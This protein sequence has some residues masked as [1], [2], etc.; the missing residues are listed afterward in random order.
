LAI[1]NN[2][3]HDNTNWIYSKTAAAAQYYQSPSGQHVW[4]IAPSGTA[5]NAITFT[6]A[7]TLTAD[8]NLGINIATPNFTS[9]N[10]KTI[11][12]NGTTSAAVSLSAGGANYAYLYADSGAA[13]FGATGNYPLSLQTNLTTKLQITGGGNVLIGSPTDSGERLQVNGTAKITGATTFGSSVTATGNVTSS[14]GTSSVIIQTTSN[15]PRIVLID[16]R[17]GGRRY[18]LGP[19]PVTSNGSFRIYDNTGAATRLNID[20]SGN[21]A[22][23][24]NTLFV[25]ATNNRVGIGTVNPTAKVDIYGTGLQLGSTSYYYNTRVINDNNSG[26]LFG[27]HNSSSIGFIGGI[28]ELAFVTYGGAGWTEKMRLSAEGNL[29]IGASTINASAKLQVDSTTQGFLPPRMTAAQRAAIASPVEGLIVFQSDG[30]VGLYLYV[31]S[32]WKSLAIVN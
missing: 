1:T 21:V 18:D 14:D 3:Y 11:D 2:G 28:N 26:L 7:M 20:S 4:Y 29:G 15:A 32:A 19:D 17:V 30:V 10:R 16:G 5:G 6:Q 22:I 24:T 31:N 23:D 25:D 13:I 8:G 27:G 12:I 9:A